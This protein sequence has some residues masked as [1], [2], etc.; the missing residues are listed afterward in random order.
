MNEIQSISSFPEIPELPYPEILAPKKKSSKV[1]Y[2]LD[3]IA[4]FSDGEPLKAA[5][6][7]GELT[8]NTFSNISSL[9][10]KD[11]AQE[12]ID[13]AG[14]SSDIAGTFADVLGILRALE[15]IAIVAQNIKKK[16]LKGIDKTI[17][18][19]EIVQ[20]F[21]DIINGVGSFLGIFDRFKVFELAKISEAM[22]KIPTIGEALAT[23]F[24]VSVVF[25]LFS[26]VSSELSIAISALKIKK[27]VKK[28]KHVNQKIKVKWN[29]PIDAAFSRN[30]ASHIAKKQETCLQN[31]L[32]LK[33]ELE[34]RA[35]CL[36]TKKDTYTALKGQIKS[37]NKV[38]K[39]FKKIK[40]KGAKG[41]YKKE[42]KKFSK[43]HDQ[44]VT[45][46][47][48]HKLQGE[49]IEKWHVI[50]EKFKNDTLTESDKA[51][52][53]TMKA[54]KV[55]KWKA[56]KVNE[57]WDIAHEVI[58]IALAIIG[59]AVSLASIGLIIAFTGNVPA[60]ALIAMGTIGLTMSAVHLS[61]SLFFNRIKKKEVSPV[62]IPDFRELVCS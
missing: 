35:E 6:F 45:L 11:A 44:L 38:S 43:L 4:Q 55:K 29:T 14:Q 12:T 40:I 56:K 15:S 21:V 53:E 34:K 58:K 22:G 54:G 23:A 19:F 16:G 61:R 57:Y 7:V 20:A 49:K 46:E 13:H 37:A 26:I 47:K 28:V 51:A 27:M 25:S 62:E 5:H 24:P 2:A 39:L 32:T 42:I 8:S 59:I 33:A 50:E 1:D 17:N 3:K 41:T 18:R 52:L 30:L 36:N 9:L 60:A 48:T 10:P 31:A